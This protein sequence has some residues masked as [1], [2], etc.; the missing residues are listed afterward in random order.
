MNKAEVAK[1]L[2]VASTIDNRKVEPE[3]VEGWFLILSDLD[4][5]V[6]LESM[7]VHFRESTDY[8][9][10][11]HIRRNVGRVLDAR[12]RDMRREF[13]E[14]E[15]VKSIEARLEEPPKCEHDLLIAKCMD[16]ILRMEDVHV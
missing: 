6:A 3:T 4:Y 5:G 7:R 9:M 15:A 12:E 2:T 11:A 8:L 1:L 13:W 16:C 14:S 10:P